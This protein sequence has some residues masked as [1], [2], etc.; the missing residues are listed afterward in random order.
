MLTNEYKLVF[1]SVETTKNGDSVVNYVLAT[2]MNYPWLIYMHISYFK[3]NEGV[4]RDILKSI[5]PNKIEK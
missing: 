3:D 5:R 1:E 2:K 4:I